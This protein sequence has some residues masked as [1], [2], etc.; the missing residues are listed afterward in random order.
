MI[1]LPKQPKI[2]KKEG[3]K[4]IFEI[5]ALY[6]GYGITIGNSLRRALLS[7]LP[8]AAITQVKI[9][10]VSHEFSTIPGILED[11]I[12]II[13]NLKQLRFKI[14]TDEPQKAFLKVKGEKEV[15]GVDF[16]IPTQAE[17]INKDCHIATLTDKSAELEMEI[18]IEKG[19]GYSSAETREKSFLSASSAKEKSTGE[20]KRSSSPAIGTILIDA[21]FS[22][23]KRVSYEIENMR[24]GERTDYDKLFL[25]IETDGIIT[26]EQAFQ[27]A[28]KI[29]ANHFS[30]FTDFFG[31]ES[32]VA[33]VP[34]AK[35]TK[36]KKIKIKN[37]KNEK[38][39]K[40]KKA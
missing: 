40:R 31:F 5:E 7:S 24:V 35:A 13:M 36:K 27:E 23:V 39:Q 11:V 3:N 2:I 17:L 12:S 28:A 8:G 25:E 30:I 15:K 6:P 20:D 4:T 32:E 38:K 16:N 21:F 19:M 14:F 18:Q 10:G 22:P 29:L 9:K 33:A 37:S 34:V 26:P 1:S